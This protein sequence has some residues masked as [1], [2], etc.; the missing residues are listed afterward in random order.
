MGPAGPR[1]DC[2]GQDRLGQD[3]RLCP[4]HTGTM[5]DAEKDKKV[6]ARAEAT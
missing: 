1:C 4:A 6:A 5:T 2:A 3:R